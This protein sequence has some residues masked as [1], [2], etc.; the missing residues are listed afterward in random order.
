MLHMSTRASK[1]RQM[2]LQFTMQ[3]RKLLSHI[4]SYYSPLPSG[5]GRCFEC[6]FHMHLYILYCVPSRFQPDESGCEEGRA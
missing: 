2:C 1:A 3:G 6:F 4:L 5:G